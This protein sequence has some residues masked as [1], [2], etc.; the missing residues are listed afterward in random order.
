MRT[1]T[2][3]HGG[4]AGGAAPDEQ[5]ARCIDEEVIYFTISVNFYSK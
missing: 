2:Q 5:R 4:P 3:P 1:A